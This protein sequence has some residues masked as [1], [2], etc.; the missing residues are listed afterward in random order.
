MNQVPNIATTGNG[1]PTGSF[2]VKGVDS[3]SVMPLFCQG[4]GVNNT[5]TM[6]LA[7]TAYCCAILAAKAPCK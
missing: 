4:S 6:F 1:T 2:K 5:S 7:V 3:V